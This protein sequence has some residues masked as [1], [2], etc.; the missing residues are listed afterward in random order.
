MK[1][2]SEQFERLLWILAISLGFLLRFSRLGAAPL[3]DWEASNALPAF[4]WIRSGVIP[5][6]AQAGY[7]LLSGIL[8]YLFGASNIAARFIPALFGSLL[9]V[10]P[11]LFRRQL[12]RWPALIAAFGL[13]LDPVLLA[14]SRQADGAIW[15]ITFSLFAV[16][17]LL[18]RQH[19]R[20]GVCLGLSLLGG[21]GVWFG[22]LGLGIAYL[23]VGKSVKFPWNEPIEEHP[24]QPVDW[25][26]IL[27]SG[28]VTL[29]AAGTLF[30]IAPFGLS[31]ATGS[32]PE[33]FRGW[34]RGGSFG[35][36]SA[37]VGLL[38]YAWFP[39]LLGAIR[40][41]SGWIRR[42]PLD[43][44]L[45]FWWLIAWLLW[46]A[47]PDRNLVDAGWMMV[48]MWALA[49][50]QAAQWLHRQNTDV[51]FSAATAVVVFV[52][53]F[54][55][56][57]NAVAILHPAGW[58]AN[59][60]LQIVKIV[61]AAAILALVVVLVGW[62]WDW[63]SAWQGIQWG[64]I[65]VLAIVLVSMSL[66]GAGLG[67]RPQAEIWR[68]GPYFSDA[69]LLQSTL[70]DLSGYKSGQHNQLSVTVVGIQSPALEWLL[71][72]FQNVE[73]ADG[74]PAAETPD[75]IITTNQIQPGQTSTY[76]GQDFHWNLQP[77]WSLMGS[78]DW[79]KWL[80]FREYP[81][82]S[83]TM[84]LWARTDLFPGESAVIPTP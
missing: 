34:L 61:V 33:F 20:A 30:M 29:A 78:V 27:L 56:V 75:I 58:S 46:L 67:K 62:G 43:Q 57:L 38:T 23:V 9:V 14:I 73:L 74:I 25:R 1:L 54:F 16:G 66:N 52:L 59:T 55:I 17:L 71:R 3:T 19:V 49:A 12:G 40:A 64:G 45:S 76:R 72:D 65:A 37:V 11:W 15:A 81:P 7:T 32:L 69:D 60:D 24:M 21:P 8:F 79:A 70:Q 42:D 26:K 51:R 36:Q 2:K 44:F 83:S 31:M 77:D 80:V 4:D 63:N 18:N 50:R 13:A 22:W 82:Q 84:I 28:L 41:I 10:L 48:P 6:G 68:S 47:Y 35:L 53:I 39:L 5:T